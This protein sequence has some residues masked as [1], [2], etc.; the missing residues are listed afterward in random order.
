V[1]M[2][3]R[4]KYAK[5]HRDAFALLRP[6]TGLNDMIIALDPGTRGSPMLAHDGVVPISDTLP[7]INPDEVLSALDGDTRDYLKLLLNAGG[8]GLKGEGRSLSA[9]LRRFEPTARDLRRVTGLVAQR[10]R[11]LARVVHNFAALSGALGAKD[12][13]LAQLVDSSNAVFRSFADQEASLRRTIALLPGALQATRG[14]L[15]RTD[16]LAGQLGPTLQ[17]LRPGA[18]ALGP[19]L[20]RARPFVTGTVAPIRDQIR[21]FTRAAL[22]TARALRPIAHDLTKVTPNLTTTFKVLNSL[23]N[24]LA[25]NPPGP[26]EE[27]YLFWASWA[28]HEANSLISTQDAQGPIRRLEFLASCSSIAIL[29]TL[30]DP[31]VN[32]VLATLTQLLDAP[33]N[34]PACPQSSQ[35]GSGV[36]PTA[37]AGG[38]G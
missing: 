3:I 14:A 19:T 31:A 15:D 2:K 16:A 35:P 7:N 20:R 32:P 24:I 29:K 38:G 4:H 26:N 21:P 13:Q 11:N 6:K 34:S 1:T 9:A 18:R 10:Q 37:G 17:D 30:S 8:Q 25:Y 33:L 27:G 22:P 36:T 12:D 5:V 23:V 28:N